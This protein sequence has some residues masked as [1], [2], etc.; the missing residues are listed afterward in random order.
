MTQNR[1]LGCKHFCDVG[2][3]EIS[4][5]QGLKLFTKW[6]ECIVSSFGNDERHRQLIQKKISDHKNNAS[7]FRAKDRVSMFF[8]NISSYLQVHKVIQPREPPSTSSLLCEPQILH[9]Y[10]FYFH[11]ALHIT[12]ISYKIQTLLLNVQQAETEG[13]HMQDKNLTYFFYK[14]LHL[15]ITN[16][17]FTET[18][19]KETLFT[20][21]TQI[22]RQAYFSRSSLLKTEEIKDKHTIPA[23]ARR[24]PR[25]AFHKGKDKNT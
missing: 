13:C 2:S 16:F 5:I 21:E 18:A 24:K 15:W 3:L 20:R 14:N 8:Q 6:K 19:R 25:S 7:V 10:L 17:L 4:K 1:K 9:T 22:Y 11:T 12:N 23:Y